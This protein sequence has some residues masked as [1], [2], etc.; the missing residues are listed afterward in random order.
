MSPIARNHHYLPQAYLAA[1][2]ETGTKDGHFFVRD[3]SNGKF[4]KTS[5]KNVAV[6]RD[7]NR[8]DVEGES[9]DII[10]CELATFEGI[11]AQSIKKIIEIQEFPPAEEFTHIIN[12]LCLLAVRNPKHRRSINGLRAET[13]HWELESLVSD[14]R[15]FENTIKKAKEAGYLKECDVSFLGMKSFIEERRYSIEF[16]SEGNMEIEFDVFDTLLPILNRR[17]WSVT[18]APPSGPIFVC[19]DDPVTLTGKDF[20]PGMPIG[21][22]MPHTEVFLPLSPRVGFYGVYENPGPP[23]MYLTPEDV[24]KRNFY[25]ASNADRHTFSPEAE[26]MIFHEGKIQ[27]IPCGFASDRGQ[28]Q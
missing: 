25:V 6:E 4:F 3:V 18:I 16:T 13:K 7:F 14:E 26:F 28:A 19:S 5:P 17:L 23:V 11:A 27:P 9:L 1:F 21:F 8:V 2:T 10:E 15:T 12:L 24:A 20:E 22:G